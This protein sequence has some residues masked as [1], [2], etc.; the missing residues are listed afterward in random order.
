MVNEH[1]IPNPAQ[2]TL[3]WGTSC[4][5]TTLTGT[6]PE[7]VTLE[8]QFNDIVTPCRCTGRPIRMGF[9]LDI[10]GYGRR[11]SPAKESL[12]RR[13][14]GVVRLVL[15]DVGVA[16]SDADSQGTGDGVVVILP[17]RLDVQHALP[18]L[19]G[20][21]RKRLSQDNAEWPDR[22]RVRMTADVGPVGLAELGFGGAMVTNIGRLLDSKPLRRWE[23]THPEHD[24]SVALSDSLYKFVV[25]E[26]VPGLPPDQF[27]RTQ[28]RAKELATTAWLWTR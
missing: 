1:D 16:L 23:T 10:V 12:Q 14:A 6:G 18:V 25:A 20:S 21:V 17:Q 24:L 5:H 2:A 13:L 15:D 9:M 27:T 3:G 11:D 4:P 26:G 7:P 8:D 22:M 28:V 19:L